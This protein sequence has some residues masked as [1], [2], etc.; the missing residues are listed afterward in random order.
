MNDFGARLRE[1][2]CAMGLSQQKFAEIGGVEANAQAKYEHGKRTPRSTYLV[3]LGEKGVDIFYLLSGTRL[4][5][6]LDSL[7]PGEREIVQRFR[8]LN[9]V[10]QHT[11]SQLALSLCRRSG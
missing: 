11:I 9:E 7:S 10:D 8:L 4:P 6:G 3:A 5:V 1:E 2:R